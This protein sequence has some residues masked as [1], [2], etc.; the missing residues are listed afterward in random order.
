MFQFNDSL[1]FQV[2]LYWQIYKLTKIFIAVRLGFILH[3]CCVHLP[4]LCC[5]LFSRWRLSSY[6][7]SQCILHWL[8]SWIC[9]WQST[10]YTQKFCYIGLMLAVYVWG[11]L[12]HLY[13]LLYYH[14]QTLLFL[15]WSHTLYPLFVLAVMSLYGFD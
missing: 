7:I 6:K 5:N 9:N 3:H 8:Y 4:A 12:F 15:Q 2:L 1:G 13:V 14:P 11:Y 10:G